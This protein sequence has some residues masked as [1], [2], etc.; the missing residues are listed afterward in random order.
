MWTSKLLASAKEFKY[1]FGYFVR[2]K[3]AALDWDGFYGESAS[4][5]DYAQ[6]CPA[7]EVAGSLFWFSSNHVGAESFSVVGDECEVYCCID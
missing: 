1:Y 3:L 6:G 5:R 7:V 4:W 2:V